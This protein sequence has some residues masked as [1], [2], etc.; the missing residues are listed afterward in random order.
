[1]T[2]GEGEG[3][4]LALVPPQSSYRPA[5]PERRP[6][7]RPR[8]VPG[9]PALRRGLSIHTERRGPV[10]RGSRDPGRRAGRAPS[11]A[12]IS[13][14]GDALRPRGRLPERALCGQGCWGRA[15]LGPRAPPGRSRSQAPRQRDLGLQASG[16]SDS[17]ALGG[18]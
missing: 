9:V 2:Q 17:P 7:P 16:V 8:F 15:A 14:R 11:R 10:P 5:V 12:G 1:M 6:R 18:I 3:A 13:P 4:A